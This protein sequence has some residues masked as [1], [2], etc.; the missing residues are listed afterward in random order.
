[1]PFSTS[2]LNGSPIDAPV[3]AGGVSVSLLNVLKSGHLLRSSLAFEGS[4]FALR[5]VLRI[6]DVDS[7]ISEISLAGYSLTSQGLETIRQALTIVTFDSMMV[8][9]VAEVM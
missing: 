4:F 6:E 1:M 2:N 7:R 3:T 9:T 8:Q 5:D